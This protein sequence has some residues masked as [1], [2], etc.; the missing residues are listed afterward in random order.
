[1]MDMVDNWSDDEV[2]GGTNSDGRQTPNDGRITP[3]PGR[4]TPP[5][6]TAD[7]GG[8]GYGVSD[9][10]SSA[11]SRLPSVSDMV[12]E[13]VS[14]APEPQNSVQMPKMGD[15]QTEEWDALDP[16]DKITY[17]WQM[18]QM[19]PEMGE[20]KRVKKPIIDAKVVKEMAEQKGTTASKGQ[21]KSTSPSCP[22][23]K[24]AGVCKSG[25][26][27]GFVHD[28]FLQKIGGKGGDAG[29]GNGATED[30][31]KDSVGHAL[32][33]KA[34]A[35]DSQSSIAKNEKGRRRTKEQ[36]QSHMVPAILKF[37]PHLPLR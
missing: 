9:Y 2:S 12:S 23:W 6:K 16:Q 3:P 26:N 18:V 33:M 5:P 36:I 15:D 32:H 35:A 11:M 10:F 14:P 34:A 28:G 17:I 19:R 1:M 4:R 21:G 37:A 7:S 30:I 20:I 22:E 29:A 13:W 24:Q 25:I 31:P 27:C 8:G